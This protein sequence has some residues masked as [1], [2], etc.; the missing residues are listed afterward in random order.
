[1][2]RI[3]PRS[4][5]VLTCVFSCRSVCLS[6]C[7]SVTTRYHVKTNTSRITPI[8]PTCRDQL[9]YLIGPRWTPWNSFKGDRDIVLEVMHFIS[10]FEKVH[11]SQIVVI[12]KKNL[13]SCCYSSVKWS[14][15]W[16]AAFPI[17][18]GVIHSSVLSPFLFAF[19]WMILVGNANPWVIFQT[20]VYGF[21]R[22]QTRVAGCDIWWVTCQWQTHKS[23]TINSYAAVRWK[24]GWLDT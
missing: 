4:S 1:M 12:N 8:P 16:S 21:D 11:S 19:F 13:I 20:R 18:F 15:V 3:L 24:C 10:R 7:S 9:S 23:C 2:H 22:I 17:N 5:E 14:N 6:A